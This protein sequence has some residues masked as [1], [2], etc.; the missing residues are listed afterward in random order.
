MFAKRMVVLIG[1]LALCVAM[2]LAAV[3]C[4]QQQAEQDTSAKS[5]DIFGNGYLDRSPVIVKVGDL[6]ITQQDLDMRYEELPNNSRKRFSGDGWEIRFLRYM[7]DEALI[8][9][10]AQRRKLYLD[11]K[12]AQLLISQRREVLKGAMRNYA[13]MQDKQPTEQQ[14]RHY[15]E[16]NKDK[17]MREGFLHVRHIPCRSREEANACYDQIRQHPGDERTWGIMVAQYSTNYESA[18]Q[19]GDLGWFSRDGFIPALPYGKDFARAV[20]DWRIGLHEPSLIGGDWHV[21]EVL[22]RELE[23]PFTFEEVRDRVAEDFLPVWQEDEVSAWLRQAK[24]T[25][26]I[27]YYGAYRPG[28]GMNEQELFER[29]WYAGTPEQ[30]LDYYNQLVEDYPQSELA[31]DAL[32]LMANLYM[33]TWS[34]VPQADRILHRL[35]N[36]Y[37]HSD[38]YDDAQ[39]FLEHLSDPNFRKPRSIEDLK[40]KRK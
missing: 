28:K 7:V 3:S 8:V 21:I 31:D 17:Y 20:W 27:E 6:E 10:E 22:E 11:P 29:A 23:R 2:A 33:D 26:D 40:P 35:V 24:Q 30:K 39:Y 34:D 9:Q 5:S 14:L 16:L 32:F 36:D 15:F 12:V 18:K 37:P 13:L 38:L 25:T 19:V 4:Q 1:V